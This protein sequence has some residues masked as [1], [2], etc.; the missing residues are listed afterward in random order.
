MMWRVAHQVAC[1]CATR[2]HLD[3]VRNDG[4]YHET[5]QLKPVVSSGPVLSKNKNRTLQECSRQTM[6]IM[7]LRQSTRVPAI[8]RN[9]TR[10]QNHNKGWL[11]Q[12][13]WNICLLW[14][15]HGV[16]STDRLSAFR[17][18]A[19]VCRTFE[20][21]HG[22]RAPWAGA[23]SYPQD[24][25]SNV[26]IALYMCTNGKRDGLNKQRQLIDCWW[27]WLTR[28]FRD[29]KSFGTRRAVPARQALRQTIK[30]V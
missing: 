10:F 4:F 17:V 16:G 23:H 18:G 27:G 13:F 25:Q 1:P 29:P 15:Q 30:G 19:G 8:P 7:A 20:D 2:C 22:N 9:G 12:E 14:R 3:A 24:R 28:T 5:K 21:L 11:L 6:V 26:S